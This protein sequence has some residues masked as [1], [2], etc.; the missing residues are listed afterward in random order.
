MRWRENE[1]GR[2]VERDC[3]Q[4]MVMERYSLPETAEDR[5]ENIHGHWTKKQSRPNCCVKLTGSD[6]C[7]SPALFCYGF[8]K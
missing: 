3:L 4:A 8:F 1:E 7:L 5:E 2:G 6:P